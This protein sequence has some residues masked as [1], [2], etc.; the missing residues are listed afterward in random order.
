MKT[1]TPF[2][3]IFLA[4]LVFWVLYLLGGA[5]VMIANWI[6]GLF[7]Y[8]ESS[9]YDPDS[10]MY[11]L[12]SVFANAIGC[13][14]GIFFYNKITNEESYVSLLVNCIIGLVLAVLIAWTE[15]FIIQSGVKKSVGFALCIIPM[16]YGIC[17]SVKNIKEN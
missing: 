12:F 13:A 1:K 6:F 3:R 4:T 17:T 7:S 16:I 8:V 5:L 9:I 10:A 2:W 11:F 14:I 15:Y